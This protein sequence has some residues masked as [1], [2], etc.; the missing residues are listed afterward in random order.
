MNIYIQ[1]SDPA[2]NI[3]LPRFGGYII[4]PAIPPARFIHNG[5]LTASALKRARQL[6]HAAGLKLRRPGHYAT[7]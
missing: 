2:R 6:A 7:A 3:Y 4:C 5:Q 1:T